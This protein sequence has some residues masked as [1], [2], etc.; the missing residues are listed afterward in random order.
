MNDNAL[1]ITNG[2]AI[3][4]D[5]L[6]FRY[7]R[8]SGPGGQHVQKT[9]T[10]VELRFDLASSPSLTGE[11]R[12]RALERLASRIDSE[13]VLHLTSQGGRSQLENRQEVVERFQ[14]LL[15]AALKPRKRRRP[16]QPS[17][18]ARRQRLDAKRQRSQLKRLRGRVPPE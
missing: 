16:T 7:A 11:Q 8:S 9:E 15:A 6:R 17:A 1:Y 18:G 12:A 5:E 10:K 13:G 4:L 14:A 2:I 3:P